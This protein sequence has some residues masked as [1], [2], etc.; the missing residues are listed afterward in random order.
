[1]GDILPISSA[2]SPS[3][4]DDI[5]EMAHLPFEADGAITQ[6]KSIIERRRT[7]IDHPSIKITDQ[8]GQPFQG[9]SI[10][11]T[12]A[13]TLEEIEKII[14][15]LGISTPELKLDGENQEEAP[16]VRVYYVFSGSD[17][18]MKV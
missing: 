13:D 3:T 9:T 10:S 5:L 2:Q 17:P 11:R 12:D 4:T 16:E 15:G 6:I 8:I 14:K 18:L 1:M 7:T